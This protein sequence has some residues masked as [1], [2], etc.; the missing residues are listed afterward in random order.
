MALAEGWLAGW[1]SWCLAD[2]QY[3]RCHGSKMWGLLA[4]VW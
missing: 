2:W 3:R 4:I 1:N